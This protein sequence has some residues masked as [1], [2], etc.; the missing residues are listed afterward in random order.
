MVQKRVG[1]IGF[2]DVQGL[3]I[4]GPAESFAAAVLE[5]A[6]GKPSN[7]YET[8][9]IGLDDRPFRTES[10][11][12]IHPQ[13]TIDSV[14]G[15]D[16]LITPGGRAQRHGNTAARIAKWLLEQGESIRRIASV[17]T[18][19]YALALTGWLDGRRVTTHW[20]FADDLG[21][22]FPKLTVD[23]DALFI[24]NG[25]FYTAAGIT[26]GI[27]LSLA[28]IEEDHGANVAL[29]VA[30]ELVVYMKRP[31]GQEQFS[32]PLKFQL[33]TSDSF[34]DLTAWMNDHLGH[35]L[36]VDRLA[37]KANLCPR[38][39]SRRFKKAYGTTPAQFVETMRLNESRARL[40]ETANT[41][42]GVALSVGFNSARAFRRVF[43]HR[44]GISPTAYRDRF[45]VRMNGKNGKGEVL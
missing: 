42:E 22:R 10:G 31:G 24:K 9:I 3:D 5:P 33:Q 12:V 44:F 45:A 26:S 19:T 29:A 36:S 2:D 38:H 13:A 25:K 1:F 11:M 35:D 21:R 4:I 41:V 7:L 40:T 28:L 18:G 37:E 43:E 6:N 15:L 32:E 14:D 20:R 30:R 27:D 34:S 8:V 17:C 23:R 16:T 39:F